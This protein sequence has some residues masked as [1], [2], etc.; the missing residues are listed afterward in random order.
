MNSIN[1]RYPRVL[2]LGETFHK[3]SGGGITLNSLFG[4]WPVDNVF[5]LTDRIKETQD[6][7]FEHFY[8]FGKNEIHSLFNT[9][10]IAHTPESGVIKLSEYSLR[11]DLKYNEINV[12][13]SNRGISKTK[14]LVKRTLKKI[15]IFE[16]FTSIVPS[17]TLLNWIDTMKPDLIYFQ[18]NSIKKI[19]FI[20]KLHSVTK[21]PFC[22]HIMD[23]HYTFLTRKFGVRKKRNLLFNKLIDLSSANIAI[24]EEM[25]KEYSKRY[26]KEFHHFQHAVEASF[27]HKNYKI[28]LSPK[29][30][31]ILYAGRI[32]SGPNNSLLVLSE[33]VE[34]LNRKGLPVEF[35]IQT[36][37]LNAEILGALAK[38]KNNHILNPIPY[39]ELPL[40][41]SEADLLV[42]PIDFDRQ[43]VEYISLSMPTKVPEYMATG[44]PILVFSPEKTALY[45]YAKS[46][47]WAFCTSNNSINSVCGVL[48]EIINNPDER[49]QVAYRA[50]KTVRRNHNIVEV[51]NNFLNL[52]NS[53]KGGNENREFQT[54]YSKF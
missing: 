10:G 7:K 51:R 48:S 27:W 34:V 23:D 52:L 43:T 15:R 40:R 6:T 29:P 33:A 30:F 45:K 26:G 12:Q 42:L 37:T 18:P 13:T 22:V 21:I 1:N 54:F 16:Y 46:Q 39:A 4:N 36:N 53:V 47:G 49:K 35:M 17:H 20:I 5:I 28:R 14:D 24:C 3:T 19:K 8:Q 25:S 9:L 11:L 41:Y 38:F 50:E 31:V 32:P 44:V 2:I